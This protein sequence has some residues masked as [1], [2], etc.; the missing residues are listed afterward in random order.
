M[1]LALCA[2]AACSTDEKKVSSKT[3]PVTTPPGANDVVV[4]KK[5]QPTYAGDATPAP[6][7]GSGGNTQGA[8]SEAVPADTSSLVGTYVT[9]CQKGEGSSLQLV[10]AFKAHAYAKNYILYGD[11]EC[12]DPLYLIQFG[13][14]YQLTGSAPALQSMDATL[15]F[16]SLTLYDEIEVERFNEDKILGYNDWALKESK[17]V[18]DKGFA[19]DG[20]NPPELKTMMLYTVMAYDQ[21]KMIIGDFADSRERRPV[22]PEGTLVFNK[23]KE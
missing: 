9:E 14:R 3:E 22:K 6:E 2:L 10:F 18:L 4:V 1:I 16:A 8:G 11:S 21:S 19:L 17:N 15:E 12:G 7:N 13:G 20:M 5:Q 23:L